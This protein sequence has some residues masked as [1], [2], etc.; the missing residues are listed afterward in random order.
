MASRNDELKALAK[1]CR[2]LATAI[3][4]EAARSQL[5]AVAERFERLAELY[6]VWDTAAALPPNPDSR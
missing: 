5:L 1:Q 2:G 6:Q 4:D 3:E